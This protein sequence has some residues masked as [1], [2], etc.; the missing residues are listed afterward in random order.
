MFNFTTLK[1]ILEFEENVNK[2]LLSMGAASAANHVTWHS[3][4]VFSVPVDIADHSASV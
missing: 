1:N 3:Y 4:T 2:R